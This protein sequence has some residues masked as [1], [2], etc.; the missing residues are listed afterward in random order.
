MSSSGVPDW[1][2]HTLNGGSVRVP[3]KWEVGELA[4]DDL[5]A[6]AVVERTRWTLTVSVEAGTLRGEPLEA[7]SWWRVPLRAGV[8]ARWDERDQPTVGDR[9]AFKYLGRTGDGECPRI[10]FACG[11]HRVA[12][13]AT[14]GTFQEAAGPWDG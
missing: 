2:D 14:S 8:L 3:K 4:V 6:G 11:L 10:D 1:V 12:E 9:V 13:P 7:G 5:L